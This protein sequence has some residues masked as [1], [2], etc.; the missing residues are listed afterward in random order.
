MGYALPREFYPSY[1]Y[2]DY[3]HWEGQWELID[4]HVY[5]MSPLPTGRHQRISGRL[6]GQL[7]RELEGCSSCE[8]SMPMDWKISEET[9]VQPDLFVACFPF[10]N[11]KFID[12][13]PTLVV[14]VLSP[15]TRLKDLNVKRNIYLD[16]GVKYYL[17]IDPD[18][19]EYTVLELSGEAY[20]ESAIGHD[21]TFTFNLKGGCDATVDFSRVWS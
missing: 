11:E 3:C 18:I 14:E 6:Y 2:D 21:G 13:P 20:K 12:R 8:V 15:S 4:G 5:A 17:I 16:Q 10:L 19:E 1:T 9:V 7:E